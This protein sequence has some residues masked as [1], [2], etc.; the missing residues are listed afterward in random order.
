MS[1]E[2]HWFIMCY[3]QITIIFDLVF[4]ISG[5]KVQQKNDLANNNA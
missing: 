3:I 2:K 1:D 5:A 4:L